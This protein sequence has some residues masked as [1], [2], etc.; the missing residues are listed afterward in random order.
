MSPPSLTPPP[1]APTDPGN[2]TGNYT[3]TINWGDGSGNSTGTITYDST[4]QDFVVAGNHTYTSAGTPTVTVT[5]TNTDGRSSV[6]SGTVANVPTLAVTGLTINGGQ[7]QT[8]IGNVATFGDSNV[9]TSP[10]YYSADINWGDGNDSPGI[11]NYSGNNTYTISGSNTFAAAGN[12]SITVTVFDTA[13]N[14]SATGTATGNIT[15]LVATPLRRA[16][17]PKARRSV[18]CCWPLST[19]MPPAPVM[20]I[21]LPAS[22]GLATAALSPPVT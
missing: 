17:P 7:G 4:N 1:D 18:M 6:S 14:T 2:S 11:I 9:G 13:N 5:V 8:F 3:A 20:T 22:T 10:S 21:T 16:T 12:L 19:T 15:G